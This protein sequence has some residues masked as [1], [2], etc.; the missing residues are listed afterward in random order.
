MTLRSCVGSYEWT[1]RGM[2]EHEGS[3]NESEGSLW[4]DLLNSIYEWTWRVFYEWNLWSTR[5][6]F[7]INPSY[8]H[9]SSIHVN[10][11]C[12][13]MFIHVHSW[14]TLLSHSCPFMSTLPSHSYPSHPIRSNPTVSFV[15]IPSHSC[16]PYRPIRTYSI[17]FMSTLLS[18]SYLFNPIH[19]NLHV[20]SLVFVY[21]H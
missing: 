18:H 5:S 8:N 10:P 2:N 19:A 4:R 9:S 15:P 3:M 16:Q 20:P 12:S 11:S 21:I 6:P 1:W 14:W 7:I 17:L 13:F